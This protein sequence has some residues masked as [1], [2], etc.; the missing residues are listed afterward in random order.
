MLTLIRNCN[1]YSPEPCGVNDILIGGGKIL[2][3]APKI[4]LQSN[5]DI[6]EIDASHCIAAP[7]FVDSLVHITGGGGEAGFAS[8]TPEMNLSDATLAGI[9]TVVAALG[10]DAVSRT[11]TDLIA[12]A[13]GLKEEGLNVYC[14]TGSYH[15]PAKT[16]TG[17]IDKDIMFIDEIIGLGE[18]AIADHRG[19]QLSAH[20]LARVAAQSRV[21][22]MLSGKRG[23]VS[24][25]VGPSDEHLQLLHDVADS[26][27][28]PLSQFYPTH[29]NRNLDLL[30]SGIHFCSQGGTIDFTTST[31]QY[32]LDHGEVAAAEA[33]AY[34]LDQGVAANKLTMSSDGHAS[35]PIFDKHNELVG[36]EVGK[37]SS[38]LASFV[39]AVHAHGVSLEHALMAVTS[40]PADILG[41]DKGRL[42]IGADADLV[43]LEQ[44]SLSPLHVFSRGQHMVADGVAIKKGMFER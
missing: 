22:G 4:D 18:V 1:L 10:T 16:L 43:L 24:I 30:K 40:N 19:S 6:D 17:D 41:I 34:C 9:T 23:T 11:H 13:K 14:Y 15:L 27:D 26:S 2:N 12:K 35:L 38:L 21:A 28:V 25:H 44:Q 31:T 29:M 7:G 42:S 5:C 32:D 8:R 39:D 20:E 36:L 3:I 33:L 37:E